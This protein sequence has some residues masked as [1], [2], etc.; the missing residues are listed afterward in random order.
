MFFHDRGIANQHR[1]PVMI[2]ETIDRHGKYA[3]LLFAMGNV[4][5]NDVWKNYANHPTWRDR[6]GLA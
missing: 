4:Y 1:W 3:T 5:N 6:G 2:D